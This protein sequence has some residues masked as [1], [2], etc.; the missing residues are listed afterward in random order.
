M[1]TVIYN[2]WCLNTQC[3]ENRML[4]IEKERK[5]SKVSY[6]SLCDKKLK[7]VGQSISIVHKGTQESK[8]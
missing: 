3:K 8:I 6:C 4:K 1:E 7:L 5:D 2:Y